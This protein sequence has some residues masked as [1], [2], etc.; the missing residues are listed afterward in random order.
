M[1]ELIDFVEFPENLTV[2]KKAKDNIKTISLF[3]FET[4]EK[5]RMMEEA[6]ARLE[7]E[8]RRR[9]R[10]VKLIEE[11]ERIETVLESQTDLDRPKSPLS[12]ID[13]GTQLIKKMMET[14]DTNSKRLDMFLSQ[15][16]EF[17]DE[18]ITTLETQLKEV[19]ENLEENNHAESKIVGRYRG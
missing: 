1:I 18:N 7:A 16:R 15:R 2:R 9:K 11:A 17:A 6:V 3:E 10:D 13:E 19:L 14:Y 12:I 8:D 5:A 4:E